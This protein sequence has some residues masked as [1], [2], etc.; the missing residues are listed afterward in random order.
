MPNHDGTGPRGRGR[1]FSDNHGNGFRHRLRGAGMQVQSDLTANT[2][3]YP[4]TEDGLRT[5]KHELEEQLN[6][7][8]KQLENKS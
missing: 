3:I 7:V 6:W 4:Y 8:N 1:C 5:R 2:P